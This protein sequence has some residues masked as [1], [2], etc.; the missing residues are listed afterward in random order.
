MFN[1]SNCVYESN[2]A[3][4]SY[5]PFS[6]KELK[7]NY[8]YL[9][10]IYFRN[11]FK[12]FQDIGVNIDDFLAEL[13][14][15][16]DLE[17]L[18]IYNIDGFT[19]LPENLLK[20]SLKRLEIYGY[21]SDVKLRL[22]SN[23]DCKLELLNLDCNFIEPS[24]DTL[25]VSNLKQVYLNYPQDVSFLEKANNIESLQIR[26]KIG[27][28][29]FDLRNLT[30]LSDLTII[31]QDKNKGKLDFSKALQ[32]K[33]IKLNNLDF[34]PTGWEHLTLLE[35]LEIQNVGS[36]TLEE[37]LKFQTYPNLKSLSLIAK[38]N[39]Q[40]IDFLGE[41][42]SL[43]KMIISCLSDSL[44]KL[45]SRLFTSQS[46]ET[47]ELNNALLPQKMPVGHYYNL[48]SMCNCILDDHIESLNNT[49][50]LEIKNILN[51]SLDS[52]NWRKLSNVENISFLQSSVLTKLPPFNAEN[53]ELQTISFHG[54]DKLNKIPDTWNTCPK[55]SKITM[56][57]NQIL[58]FNNWDNFP[59]IKSIVSYQDVKFSKETLLWD[60][61]S[62]IDFICN[63][64][65]NYYF[66]SITKIALNSTLS[67]ETKLVIGSLMLEES[68]EIEKIQNFKVSFLEIFNVKNHILSQLGWEKLY[69]L[70]DSNAKISEDNLVGKSIA[71]LGKTQNSKKYY[72]EKLTDLGSNYFAKAEANTEII[73][74]GEGF[75]LPDKFW[76][77]P[78]YFISETFLYSLIKDFQ[79]GVIQTLELNEL[80]NLRQLIWSNEIENDKIVLEMIK[81]GG[82]ADSLIPDLMVVA[83]TSKD[84]NVKSALK[85][86]LKAIVSTG[87][88][89]ILSDR[90]N[91]KYKCQ[92][93]TYELYDSEFDLPQ[94]AVT[95]YKRENKYLTDFFSIGKS[96]ENIYRKELFLETCRKYLIKP[97]L[98]RIAENF[99]DD[100]LSFML[101]QPEFEG[102]IKRLEIGLCNIK[103]ILPAL[104]KH[105]HTLNFLSYRTEV[106]E[107]PEEI[108]EFKK[109][110][111]LKVN[112]DYFVPSKT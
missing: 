31:S 12:D 17:T 3:F 27:N 111:S 83:K 4:V 69:L 36:G 54:T 74:V 59:S 18:I 50:N 53:K 25:V 104:L 101:S 100:E 47:I 88:Q 61:L 78:H 60:N 110:K 77:F 14:E 2:S 13:V 21:H 15:A 108:I 72:K 37:K 10:E 94:F 8:P 99:T 52:I 84:D 89:K 76:N 16:F 97:H 24:L 58:N 35:T 46:L 98:I 91:L 56:N 44:I 105:K 55:L 42:P 39:F 38:I 95:F 34:L 7:M 48:I 90:T 107:L 29:N 85:K 41:M 51:E 75:E 49:Q 68:F 73:V 5:D 22:H 92:Y 26:N 71:I 79:P 65:K 28:I 66:K 70:N 9:K 64:D 87:C 63:S 1:F 93:E 30:K 40:N 102:K 109:L 45:D 57:S 11:N 80:H 33:N 6:I 32:L 106:K 20:K 103:N 112:S 81:G 86:L 82:I 62:S 67:K 43:E 19:K 23:I 96:N